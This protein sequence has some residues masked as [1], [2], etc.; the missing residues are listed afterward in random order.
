MRGRLGAIGAATAVLILAGVAG[1]G[2]GGGDDAVRT[3]KTI[4]VGR[5]LTG[6]LDSGVQ[7]FP[8]AT[9]TDDL[10]VQTRGQRACEWLQTATRDEVDLALQAYEAYKAAEQTSTSLATV[11][12]EAEAVEADLGDI[13][14][15]VDLQIEAAC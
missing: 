2:C 15:G 14:D 7:A 10:L 11:D 1:G 4:S 3:V 8:E 6:Y 5:A 13:K 12:A 9:V